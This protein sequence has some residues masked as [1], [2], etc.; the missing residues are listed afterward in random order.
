MAKKQEEGQCDQ[1]QVIGESKWQMG[2]EWAAEAVQTG[3]RRP[4]EG[5]QISHQVPWEPSG[6][7][8][9]EDW[10]SGFISYMLVSFLHSAWRLSS[11][12]MLF[13]KL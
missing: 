4:W 10:F 6:G 7:L 1:S 9:I 8:Y 5:A 12:P 13:L 3:P 2:L 11:F